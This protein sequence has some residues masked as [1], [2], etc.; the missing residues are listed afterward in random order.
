MYNICTPASYISTSLATT[1]GIF[2]TAAAFGMRRQL[3]C[4][5]KTGQETVAY[6]T[7]PLKTH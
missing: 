4:V 2:P 6:T 1:S 3:N 5:N 7:D